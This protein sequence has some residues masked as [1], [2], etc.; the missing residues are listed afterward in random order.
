M[1]TARQNP[2]GRGAA[3]A[4]RSAGAIRRGAVKAAKT[5]GAIA[6]RAGTGVKKASR[7]AYNATKE[8]LSNVAKREGV[9]LA[10][11]G[12]GYAIDRIF[13]FRAWGGWLRPSF[14]LGLGAFVVSGLTGGRW[15][16]MA[17]NAGQG[18]THHYLARSLD[19]LNEMLTPGAQSGTA[20]TETPGY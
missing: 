15:S 2:F 14:F 18:V 4:R 19:K 11:H 5:T 16:V 12:A 9:S 1:Q 17:R 20:G 8:P 7:A 13:P 6:K 3:L 10:A